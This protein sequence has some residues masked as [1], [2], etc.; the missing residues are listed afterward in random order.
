V[1]EGIFAGTIH[2]KIR[3]MDILD[4]RHMQMIFRKPWKEVA[5]QCGFSGAGA[6]TDLECMHRVSPFTVSWRDSLFI[7]AGINRSDLP[8]LIFQGR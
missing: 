2:L 3:G 5:D 7:I 1:Y 6:S 8:R 4:D